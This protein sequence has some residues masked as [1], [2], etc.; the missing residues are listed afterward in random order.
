MKTNPSNEQN[1]QL[2]TNSSNASRLVTWNRR[3]FVKRALAAG[4]AA[5]L[6]GLA[7]SSA[8]GSPPRGGGQPCNPNQRRMQAYQ[9]RHDAAVAE[10]QQPLPQHPDNGDEARYLNKIGSYSKGLPHNDL[11][12]VDLTAYQTYLN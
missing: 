9:I 6:A 8:N 10:M 12:E 5:N 3:T 7:W 4:A 1:T 11:G 2:S